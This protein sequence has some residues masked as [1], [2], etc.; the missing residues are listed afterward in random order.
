MSRCFVAA[1]WRFT[2]FRM[3]ALHWMKA[4]EAVFPKDA[5]GPK[6]PREVGNVL[7]DDVK[8][9]GD[10][11]VVRKQRSEGA[12]EFLARSF[13]V[14]KLLGGEHFY[15]ACQLNNNRKWLEAS[16]VPFIKCVGSFLSVCFRHFRFQLA[17]Y[18]CEVR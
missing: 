11:R 5:A 13:E 1:L 2:E 16:T 14:I 8:L 4:L 15:L 3:K 7:L 9:W 12:H 6:A 18:R 10:D 17:Q